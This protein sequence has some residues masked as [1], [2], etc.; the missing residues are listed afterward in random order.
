MVC[1]VAAS[2]GEEDPDGSSSSSFLAAQEQLGW[3]CC[4]FLGPFGILSA[5]AVAS[6][7]D[8]LATSGWVMGGRME[9]GQ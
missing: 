2:V 6:G 5:A 8:V 9:R 1:S 4:L 7:T 3:C